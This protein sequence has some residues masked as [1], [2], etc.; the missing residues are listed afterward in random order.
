VFGDTQSV[1]LNWFKEDQP[2]LIFLCAPDIEW[3]PDP[4]RANET[5]RWRLFELYE[6]AL[7]N[8]GK[9]YTVVTGLGPQREEPVMISVRDLFEKNESR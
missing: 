3:Q 5:D 7:K 2:D 4:L 9:S 8:A 1:F 6:A